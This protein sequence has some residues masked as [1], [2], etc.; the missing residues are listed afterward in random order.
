MSDL[1]NRTNVN[2]AINLLLDDA[3][4]N[5]AIQPSDHNTLLQN[6]LDT[7]ANGLSVTL[8]TNPET[9][10]QDIEITSGDKLK[11]KSSTFFSSLITDTL[12]ADRTLTLPNNT[13]T[14]ALLSDITGG[15]S[16]YS[17]N[18]TVPSSTVATITDSLTFAGGKLILSSTTNGILLNR[19]TTSEMNLLTGMLDNEIVFNK[20]L[21][22]LYRYD[23]S[24]WVALTV[25]AGIVGVSDTSGTPTFY[26]NYT[27]AMSAATAGQTINQYGNITE[28]GNVSITITD[29]VN[30]NMNGFT[31]TL[32]GSNNTAFIYSASGT[33]TKFIN[34]TV[35]KKNSP[36]QGTGGGNGLEVLLNPNLDCSGL[37]VISDGEQ[38]LN[39][40]TSGSGQGLITNGSFIFN[41]TSAGFICTIEGRLINSFIDTNNGV[42][43]LTGDGLYNSTIK[44]AVTT[45]SLGQIKNCI[46]NNINSAVGLDIN[47]A[48]AFNCTV[49]SEN[50]DA[51]FIDNVA[52]QINNCSGSSNAGFGINLQRGKAFNSIGK[53]QS[54][55]GLQVRLNTAFA[56]FCTGESE[57]K[58]GIYLHSGN[59]SNCI[60]KSNYNN[61]DGHGIEVFSNNGFVINCSAVVV[62]T[63]ANAIDSG[64]L[65]TRSVSI[66]GLTGEGM[67]TLIST[68]ITNTQTNTID[69][70]G[71]ILI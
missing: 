56:F 66:A 32:D 57:I 31:Y 43:R 26:A 8:R 22:A 25:G 35:I 63:G 41:G 52:S 65:T 53:S 62:N 19:V 12:T 6:I 59:L 16:I 24:N 1:G 49:T 4:P 3:Q 29:E 51:I 69:T 47:G 45:T 67:T 30:V 15:D 37:T 33:T 17:A 10:G 20:D 38:V 27:A 36:T 14:V 46:I 70:F 55:W 48:Q 40:N 39:F 23:G 54:L 42:I 18:G 60:G 68:R 2:T 44:G 58:G 28:T 61:V 11:Y 7:L 5:E 71:N 64:N 50:S 9:G 13:G 21:N 34:G